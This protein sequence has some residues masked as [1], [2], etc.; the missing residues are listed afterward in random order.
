MFIKEL[1]K[2][3]T[4]FHIGFVLFGLDL[5]LPLS[6]LPVR[7][8]SLCLCVF[9]FFLSRKINLNNLLSFYLYPIM[10]YS[11]QCYFLLY[12][13][14]PSYSSWS[15]AYH[16]HTLQ[17]TIRIGL[18]HAIRERGWVPAISL[19]YL[20]LCVFFSVLSEPKTETTEKKKLAAAK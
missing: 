1:I 15:W 18:T 8:V 2:I 12:S 5:F 10:C 17:Y 4:L 7:F 11:Y 9:I 20:F 19:I 14:L 6:P 3:V 16:T 13:S